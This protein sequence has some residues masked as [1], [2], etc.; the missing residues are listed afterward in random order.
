MLV[1]V[2]DIV[3]FMDGLAPRNLA[4]SW[5]NTGLAIGDP[6]H[7]VKKV[8]VAL[9]VTDSVIDEAIGIGADLIL[10]H[11]PMLLF[12]KINSITKKDALGNRIYKLIENE[13]AALSAHTN[14]D[15][16]QGGIND[17]LA[18][19]IGLEDIEILEET[20]AEELKKIVTYV[21]ESHLDAVRNA[22]C[23]A[24]GGH[25]GH[26]SH[27]TFQ[28]S[29]E[30]TFLPLAGTAPYIGEEGVL[31]K[32]PETRIETIAPFSKV[33]K[34]VESMIKAHPYEEVAYDIYPVEQKGRR[35]GIGRIGDLPKPMRFADFAMQLK[36]KLNIDG[37]I[38]LVGDPNQEIRRVGLCTGSGVEFVAAAKKQGADAYLTG[39]L[40][41]HEAQRALELGICVGDITHYASEVIIVPVLKEA[42]RK[43]A[44]ERG[45]ELEV[46]CS[47]IDGQTFWTI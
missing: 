37:I 42:L 26:Y 29:G 44:E 12:K 1:T 15:I 3:K 27:C 16:A 4:E 8:L 32:T 2:N 18:N 36:Q 23:D 38:R 30:G 39:D 22:M 33:E 7:Q 46:V 45:W 24:G 14:L 31:E 6:E 9:D 34:I 41:F 47:Q 17:V 10:T 19:M 5:D 35:E 20:W 43:E 25:I 40:K 21:P 28:S 11:H 13:I